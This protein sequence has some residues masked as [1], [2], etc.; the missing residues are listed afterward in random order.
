L[1]FRYGLEVEDE[2]L[3][4]TTECPACQRRES[5]LMRGLQEGDLL[6]CPCGF[7]SR[8]EARHLEVL[9]GALADLRR[10]HGNLL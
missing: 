10:R 8:L 5:W 4:L 9:A 1:D 7:S 2:A 6:R 3:F